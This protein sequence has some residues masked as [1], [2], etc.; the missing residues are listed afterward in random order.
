GIQQGG[1]TQGLFDYAEEKEIGFVYAEE[2]LH[3]I[4]PPVKDKVERFIHNHD[5]IMFT[6]C[7][8][9][10]DSAYAPGVSA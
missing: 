8:D 2:L 4:S 9:V 3:Q 6:I 10:I 5:V 7:M 1:N